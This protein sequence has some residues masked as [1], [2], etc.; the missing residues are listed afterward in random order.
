MQKELGGMET[1]QEGA[2]LLHICF[3]VV[4]LCHDH[5]HEM[6]IQTTNTKE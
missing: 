4:V 1:G 5:E 2:F 3:H 6:H